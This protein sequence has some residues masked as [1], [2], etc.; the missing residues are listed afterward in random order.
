MFIYFS[1]GLWRKFGSETL[2]RKTWSN[3]LISD[4]GDTAVFSLKNLYKTNVEV[5]DLL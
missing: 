3:H 2:V 1:R 5:E 4:D